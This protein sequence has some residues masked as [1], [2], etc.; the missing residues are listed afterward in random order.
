MQYFGRCFAYAY[1]TP[2][3]AACK[4]DPAPFIRRAIHA[5]VP[6]ARFELLGP[7]HGA[8]TT[9]RFCSPDDREAAWRSS[10]SH[11]TAPR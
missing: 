1:I 9:L 6:R 5:V 3:G 4:A 10:P 2:A 8:D 7:N 11:W